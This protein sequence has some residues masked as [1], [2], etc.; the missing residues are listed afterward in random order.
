MT[1]Y[2][3]WVYKFEEAARQGAE[4]VLIIHETALLLILGKLLKQVGPVSR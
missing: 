2:G 3:R 1:Y 4:T